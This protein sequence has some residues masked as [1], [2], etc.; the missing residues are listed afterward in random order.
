M[1]SIDARGLRKLFGGV[2]AVNDLSLSVE[3]GTFVSLLGPS[4]CGKTTTLRML[5][6]LEVPDA[7][8]IRIG[9]EVMSSAEHRRFVPANDRGLGMVFQSYAIWPHMTVSQNIAYPLKMR[10]VDKR[11][12][13]DRVEAILHTVGLDGYGDRPSSKLS[14]GQQQRVALARAMVLNPRV[15]LLDE[16]LS[17][18]DAKLRADLRLELRSLQ[19]EVGITTVYVTHDQS[20]ALALSDR[21]IVMAAG[22]VQQDGP[23]EEIY[24]HPANRFVA[25][26]IGDFS[27]VDG[28]IRAVQGTHLE[29]EVP[30]NTAQSRVVVASDVRHR[31]GA[32]VTL[33]FRPSRAQVVQGAPSGDG[34]H[35]GATVRTGVYLGERREYAMEIGKCEVKVYTDRHVRLDDGEQCCL[36]FAD[37][38]LMVFPVDEAPEGGVSGDAAKHSSHLVTA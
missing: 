12:R 8:E 31:V 36:R 28:T 15:L 29:V 21:I 1:G 27:H 4:G 24:E 2:P 20:E 3:E 11:E 19:Q 22:A 16:P 35:L 5:A 9:D 38:D 14:G 23:P 7:G 32:R 10:R 33:A 30:G 17:N 34:V 18:L 26:F 13:A 25:A 37:D 6:G